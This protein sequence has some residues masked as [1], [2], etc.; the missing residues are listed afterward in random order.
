MLLS[1]AVQEKRQPAVMRIMK[2]QV[3]RS[4][5]A[6]EVISSSD[7]ILSIHAIDKSEISNLTIYK[8]LSAFTSLYIMLSR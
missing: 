2:K 8:F 1:K 7:I 3:H 4:E 6:N 5:T